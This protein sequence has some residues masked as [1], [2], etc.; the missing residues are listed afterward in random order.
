MLDRNK[1]LKL[2][3]HDQELSGQREKIQQEIGAIKVK[4]QFVEKRGPELESEKRL[5]A[6]SRNFKEAARL[7]AEAKVLVADK[8]AAAVGMQRYLVELEKLEREVEAQIRSL[9]NIE[10]CL[11]AS[12]KDASVARCE[13]LRLLAAATRDERDA[14]AE[15]EDFSEAESLDAEAEALDA[16]ANEL[17]E[18]LKLD[19]PQFDK[20]SSLH[21]GGSLLTEDCVGAAGDEAAHV[22]SDSPELKKV[23]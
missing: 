22:E 21:S 6:S 15:L 9:A 14:A 1:I 12:E 23:D 11:A 20:L 19:G 3:V 13:R 5:A 4:F 7:A 8:E 10:S 16:E 18:D 17:K 2:L